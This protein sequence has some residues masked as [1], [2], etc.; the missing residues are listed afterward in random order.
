M[1][2]VFQPWYRNRA[3]GER[4]TVKAWYAEWQGADSKTHRKKVGAKNLAQAYLARKLGEVERQKAGIAPPPSADGLAPLAALLDDYLKELA[5]RDTDATY[6]RTVNARLT[7]IL[8]ECGW[9]MWPDVAAAAM[10]QFLGALRAVRSPATANGYLRDA[11][12]FVGWIAD[13]LGT[14]SPLRKVAPFPE[15]AD[16]RRSKAILSDAELAALVQAA[17]AAPRRHNTR[18]G[19][20]DRAVLYQVAAFTGLRASELASLTP[21]CFRLDADVPAVHVAAEHQ[22]GRRPDPVPLPPHLVTLLR[23][24]LKGRPLHLPLW[25]GHWARD[26]RQRK[27]LALD[28]RRAGIGTPAPGTKYSQLGPDG[29][30]YTFHSLRRGYITRL[31][32]SGAD[33]DLVRRLARH[34]SITT[35]LNHY[36]HADLPDL[37]A[38]ARKLKPLP[39]PK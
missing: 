17:S 22:K 13:R 10:Q 19:G 28:L 29:K 14:A 34:R 16:R 36:T 24:W 25:P 7:R 18:I 8:T 35:T 39:K 23:K 9:L 11:K 4:V 21:A 33:V 31:I 15:E 37:A 1:G 32:R 20:P 27:W 26:R 6:R 3:T 38:A 2:R 30:P 5:S 12:A